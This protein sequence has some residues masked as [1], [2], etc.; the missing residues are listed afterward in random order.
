[1]STTKKTRPKGL[2][3]ELTAGRKSPPTTSQNLTNE[4]LTTNSKIRLKDEDL[5][6]IHELGAGSG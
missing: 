2:K 5:I 3:V 1:M 4:K 6:F